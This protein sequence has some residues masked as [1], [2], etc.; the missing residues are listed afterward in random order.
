MT[1][2]NT[3]EVWLMAVQST[4]FMR[5]Q[6]AVVWKNPAIDSASKNNASWFYRCGT[7]ASRQ[8]T[9]NPH[10]EVYIGDASYSSLSNENQYTKNP[11]T[12]LVGGSNPVENISQIGSFPQVGVKKKNIWNHHLEYLI[13]I[14]VMYFWGNLA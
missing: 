1:T 9:T 7:N 11:H 6:T 3:M 12:V 2:I 4:P 5:A 8:Q 14:S 10:D 13:S